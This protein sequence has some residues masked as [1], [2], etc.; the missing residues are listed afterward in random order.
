MR[1]FAVGCAVVSRTVSQLF[2]SGFGYWVWNKRARSCKL[3][4]FVFGRKKIKSKY[5]YI[6]FW[7]NCVKVPRLHPISSNLNQPLFVIMMQLIIIDSSN[8]DLWLI[9]FYCVDWVENLQMQFR[10]LCVACAYL[11]NTDFIHVGGGG[12]VYEL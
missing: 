11:I 8:S 7:F 5:I 4:S 9:W 3:Q 12:R 6:S 10:F 2:T 1:L